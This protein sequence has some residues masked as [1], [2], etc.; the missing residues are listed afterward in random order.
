MYTVPAKVNVQAKKLIESFEKGEVT[1]EED[2]EDGQKPNYP[3]MYT[4]ELAQPGTAKKRLMELE[5]LKKEAEAREKP[6]ASTRKLSEEMYGDFAHDRMKGGYEGSRASGGWKNGVEHPRVEE[7][8]EEHRVVFTTH[9]ERGDR[10]ESDRSGRTLVLIVTSTGTGAE[11]V[12]D[13]DL[14]D[15]VVKFFKDDDHEV[16]V[17][18]LSHTKGAFP[19]HHSLPLPLSFLPPLSL[20]PSP[21]PLLCLFSSSCVFLLFPF[22]VLS[23]STTSYSSSCVFLLLL[24]SFTFFLIRIILFHR[25]LFVLIFE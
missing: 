24:S 19:P 13:K 14:V 21:L 18:D 7:S 15:K 1:R 9:E 10:D 23:L 17:T 8:L 3:Q 11:S 5:R 6:T 22:P 4:M 16:H 25:F 20:P 12:M 2:E